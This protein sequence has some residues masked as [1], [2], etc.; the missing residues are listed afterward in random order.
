M[1]RLVVSGMA[2]E[3]E[4]CHFVR[5]FL[6]G[7]LLLFTWRACTFLKGVCAG[8][9]RTKNLRSSECVSLVSVTGV[10]KRKVLLI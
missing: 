8:V 3:G 7:Q 9:R 6:F 2:Q 10:K 4:K 1:V 5:I